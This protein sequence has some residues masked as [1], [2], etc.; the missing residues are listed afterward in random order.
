MFGQRVFVTKKHSR[1]H[2]HILCQD[3]R[4]TRKF[5]RNLSSDA[6]IGSFCKNKIRGHIATFPVTVENIMTR[7][8]GL[9]LSSGFLHK[10]SSRI[11]IVSIKTLCTGKHSKY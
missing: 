10:F 5:G 8:V 6:W 2:G 1:P 7:N 4:V 3:N 9:S 11:F